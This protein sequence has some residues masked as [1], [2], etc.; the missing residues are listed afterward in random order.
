MELTF[1]LFFILYFFPVIAKCFHTRKA[2]YLFQKGRNTMSIFEQTSINR[3]SENTHEQIV[4]TGLAYTCGLCGRA[5][6]RPR[7][8]AGRGLREVKER[9]GKVVV[10]LNS[11]SLRSTLV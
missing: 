11:D 7:L 9:D 6:R 10:R 8:R 2:D 4:H 5:A 1:S 3:Q